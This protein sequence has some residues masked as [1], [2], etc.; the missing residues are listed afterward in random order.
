MGEQRRL[1][2]EL[3]AGVSYRGQGTTA[4]IAQNRLNNINTLDPEAKNRLARAA[5]ERSRRSDQPQEQITEYIQADEAEEAG[6]HH[7]LA[8]YLRD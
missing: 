4:H 1:E 3:L 6:S 5:R 2:S 7:D 8:D